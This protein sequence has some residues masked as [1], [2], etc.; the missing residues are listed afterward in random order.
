LS[1]DLTAAG[2]DLEAG[3]VDLGPRCARRRD[4]PADPGDRLP[5]AQQAAD[6]IGLLDQPPGEWK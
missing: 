1:L 4:G 5:A 6:D 3:G 2:L